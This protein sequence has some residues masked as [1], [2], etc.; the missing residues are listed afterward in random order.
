MSTSLFAAF[1]IAD[2]TAIGELR[3]RHRA[4]CRAGGERI[5]CTRRPHGC[6]HW[7]GEDLAERLDITSRTVR[8]GDTAPSGPVS[9]RRVTSPT[10]RRSSDAAPAMG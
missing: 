3:R 9:E 1:N 7:S 10:G 8:P 6:S 2:G 5:S 4:A